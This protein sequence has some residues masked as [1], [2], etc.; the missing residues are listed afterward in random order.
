[1]KRRKT[2]DIFSGVEKKKG[3]G[4][5]PLFK[6]GVTLR[7]SATKDITATFRR[8]TVKM[9]IGHINQY[10]PVGFAAGQLRF[11]IIKVTQGEEKELARKAERVLRDQFR[12]GRSGIN[13]TTFRNPAE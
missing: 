12:R 7:K 2:K 11:E 13:I 9:P 6:T 4:T 8:S 10:K 1:M 5:R 3:A